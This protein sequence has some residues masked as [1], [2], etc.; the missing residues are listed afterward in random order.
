MALG[1]LREL[2]CV[3]YREL[4]EFFAFGVLGGQKKPVEDLFEWVI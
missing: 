3:N 2:F 4:G 1:G